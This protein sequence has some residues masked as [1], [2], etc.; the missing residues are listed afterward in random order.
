V[1]YY[2]FPVGSI[3]WRAD[4]RK[5]RIGDI[6]LIA[7]GEASIVNVVVNQQGATDMKIG[8]VNVILASGVLTGA[9]A[10]TGLAVLLG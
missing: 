3:G 8:I 7:L 2:A 9:L 1:N 10:A 4:Y 6:T 5:T